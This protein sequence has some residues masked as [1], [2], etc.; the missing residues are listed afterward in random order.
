MSQLQKMEQFFASCSS[1]LEQTLENEIK[2]SRFKFKAT[3]EGGVLFEGNLYEGYR[4]LLSLRTA[5]RV[6]I[7]LHEEKNVHQADEVYSATRKVN[8]TQVFD[9]QSRFRVSFSQTYEKATPNADTPQ[10]LALKAKDAIVDIFREKLGKR[11]DVD[12]EESE[13]HIR[14][15]R[16]DRRLKVYLDLSG[17]PLSERGYRLQAGAAP[18]RETLAAAMVLNTFQMTP[19][20]KTLPFFD[21]F[22]G[23]GTILIE[24]LLIHLNWAPGLLRQNFGVF[25]WLGHQQTV[26][27]QVFENLKKVRK[28]LTDLPPFFGS[29]LDPEMTKRTQEILE[30]LGLADRVVL[31]SIP[32]DA[33]TP[34]ANAGVLI[35]NPPY[36]IRLGEENE[37][38]S[39]YQNIGQKL[40][41]HYQNWMATVISSNPKLI[42]AIALKASKKLKVD[43][44]GLQS[45]IQIYKLY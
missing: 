34:P 18:I 43:H 36:G 44:G 16:H 27:E 15:H 25:S 17:A 29:D 22:C 24:A 41:H 5:S 2:T 13:I 7:L 1:G 14:L 26:F 32:F 11:P 39:L 38:L 45:E 20:W 40:K 6:F 30:E 37:L 19:D 28:P 8:W 10:F 12:R 31:Q 3:F 33:A 42:H 21:P 9:V 35:T 23:S 4:A